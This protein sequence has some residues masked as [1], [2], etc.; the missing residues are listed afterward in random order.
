MNASIN[1][2]DYTFEPGETILQVARRNGIFIPTLCHFRPLNHKPGT[3]RVCLAEVTDRNGH[4]E[5]LTTCNPP[6]KKACG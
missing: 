1:G 5:M 4:T 3:C 2:R 6:W